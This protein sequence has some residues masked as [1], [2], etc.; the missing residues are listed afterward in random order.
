MTAPIDIGLEQSDLSLTGQQD[1]FDSQ[2]S[3]KQLRKQGGL[4]RILTNED[5]EVSDEEEDVESMHDSSGI[6]EE[7]RRV[8]TLE[9]ELDGLY[10]AYQT[11]LKERDAK[12]RS[13]LR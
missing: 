1:L 12:Y 5:G 6:G 4:A 2:D 9:A 8:E 11:H 13:T 3:E 7:E 10:D